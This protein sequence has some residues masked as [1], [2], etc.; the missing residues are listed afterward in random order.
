MSGQDSMEMVASYATAE[1][2]ASTLMRAAVADSKCCDN[3]TIIVA[4]L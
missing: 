2:M 3:V 1:K 4:R